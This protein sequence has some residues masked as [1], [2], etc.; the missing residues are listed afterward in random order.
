MQSALH[1]LAGLKPCAG[2]KPAPR[3][4][5]WGPEFGRDAKDAEPGPGKV[6]GALTPLSGLSPV[7]QGSH[8]LRHGLLSFVLTGF[9][10]SLGHGT[11][12]VVLTA[13]IPAWVLLERHTSRGWR[14]H[15]ILERQSPA[16]EP[17][18]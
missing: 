4:A 15:T 9:R 3:G 14:V 13:F 5:L 18:A 7:A 16:D 2:S 1:V 10:S 17:G 12:S 8:G 11:V 6:R